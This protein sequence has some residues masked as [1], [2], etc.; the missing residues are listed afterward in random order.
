MFFSYHV[1]LSTL[2]FT[3]T[4]AI[5]FPEISLPN[6]PLVPRGLVS[7]LYKRQT[8]NTCPPVWKDVA[9][10][11]SQLFLDTTTAECNDDARAAIRASAFCPILQKIKAVRD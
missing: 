11:L 3:I 4:E 5:S 9:S 2:V 6:Q 7:S 10:E 8:N 1:V